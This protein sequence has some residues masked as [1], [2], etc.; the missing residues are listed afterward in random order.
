MKEFEIMIIKTKL[1]TKGAKLMTLESYSEI[2]E[3]L[4]Q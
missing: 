2:K 3:A 4:M 1:D